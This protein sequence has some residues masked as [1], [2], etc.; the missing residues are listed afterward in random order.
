M[1]NVVFTIGEF[2]RITGLSI[3]TLRHYHEK[4]L[5][6]PSYVDP[7][8]GYRYYD[9]ADAEIARVVIAFRE[10]EFSLS[11]IKEIL[12][13]HDDD[14]EILDCLERRKQELEEEIR[15]RK[16]IAD[17]LRQ[18]INREIEGKNAMQT[19]SFSVQEKIIEP[20]LIAGVRF[21]G[22]YGDCG[23]GFAK[24]A[25]AFGRHLCGKAMCLYYDS[26]YREN[27]ADIE[28]C[29]PVRQAKNV[30]GVSVHELPGGKC[31]SLLHQ[32]PYEELG[33]SYAKITEYI[34]QKGYQVSL[35]C[36]EVYLKGP[37]MIFRG[38]PK[39]YLTEIQMLIAP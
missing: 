12:E 34:K 20:Q 32:G 16:R 17:S 8:T 31:V 36:R 30:E 21:K 29:I 18:I 3:K 19:S 13:N 14:G 5:M 38:S 2:S 4:G 9:G 6:A 24:V 10:M 26:E 7:Q 37:G 11:E 25:K 28:A 15:Q 23:K 1:E 35:P 27:D 22:K 33:R 39:K